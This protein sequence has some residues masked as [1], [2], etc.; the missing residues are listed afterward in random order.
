MSY[1]RFPHISELSFTGGRRRRVFWPSPLNHPHR[2]ESFIIVTI[3]SISLTHKSC[4]KSTHISFFDNMHDQCRKV[5]QLQLLLAVWLQF[6]FLQLKSFMNRQ[7][8]KLNTKTQ[9]IMRSRFSF[10]ICMFL[11]KTLTHKPCCYGM[12]RVKNKRPPTLHWKSISVSCRGRSQE[13]WS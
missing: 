7:A 8:Y 2:S 4:H 1:F 10:D 9:Y 6:F 3:I 5:P 12:L 11:M 13:S